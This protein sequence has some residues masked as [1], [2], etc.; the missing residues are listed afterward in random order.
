VRT[1]LGWPGQPGQPALA[2]LL[3]ALWGG[4][5]TGLVLRLRRALREA[6]SD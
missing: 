6:R 3:L 4:C 2:A 5:F 1:A